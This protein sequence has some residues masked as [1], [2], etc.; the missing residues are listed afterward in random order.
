MIFPFSSLSLP[1]FQVS[2]SLYGEGFSIYSLP[3]ALQVFH[4]FLQYEH[5]NLT[6]KVLLNVWSELLNKFLAQKYL[7]VF[8]FVRAYILHYFL[9]A[10]IDKVG[11]FNGDSLLTK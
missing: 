9:L 8:C 4:G 11:N 5:I 1:L 3:R 2:L 10:V 6:A 7:I